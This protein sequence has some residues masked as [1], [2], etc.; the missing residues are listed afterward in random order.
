MK[1][2][3]IF[4]LILLLILMAIPVIAVQ[5][6]YVSD[7]TNK[8]TFGTGTLTFPNIS[9]T[10]NA[11]VVRIF[12]DSSTSE[13][14]TWTSQKIDSELQAIFDNTTTSDASTW[15]SQ[16]IDSAF[17]AIFDNT[18]TSDAS[19]WTSQKID[20]E[21]QSAGVS[22]PLPSPVEIGSTPVYLRDNAGVLEYSND[23]SAWNPVGSGSG[24]GQTS[25]FAL[26]GIGTGN[27]ANAT[28]SPS[29][30]FNNDTFSL[31][32]VVVVDQ[33]AR[34][35]SF[36]K[37][38]E[39][40]YSE[41]ILNFGK[42]SS[43]QLQITIGNNTYTSG[44]V[45]TSDNLGVPMEVGVICDQT[46]GTVA[47]FYGGKVEASQAATYSYP[48][49]NLNEQHL[50]GDGLDGDVFFFSIT[51]GLIFNANTKHTPLRE[52]LSQCPA[53]L[54]QYNMN[55]AQGSTLTDR[56]AEQTGS[57]AYDLTVNGTWQEY[58]ENY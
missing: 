18:T 24:G 48:T 22:Y 33:L 35:E 15:T 5:Y 54:I 58:S 29:G 19:T 32:G 10:H 13:T 41:N 12:D 45:F 50:L 6:F 52:G 25:E 28:F 17:Q 23:G 7:G 46:G 39:T 30:H 42:D 8:L 4:L 20:T 31:Y 55:E 26:R 9:G 34:A 56:Y 40:E 53:C 49:I 51:K 36:Y 57:T 38:I 1:K 37:R 43:N 21:I 11:I 47:F 2:L 16:K 14:L 27:L 3:H 44:T